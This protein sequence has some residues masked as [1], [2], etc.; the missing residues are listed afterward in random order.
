MGG[1]FPAINNPNNRNTV[2]K[3]EIKTVLLEFADSIEGQKWARS[4]V[5]DLK[6]WIANMPIE[7]GRIAVHCEIHGLIE[8]DQGEFPTLET[9]KKSMTTPVS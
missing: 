4:R 1:E 2:K 7:E 9:F 6:N 3:S 8:P 5:N